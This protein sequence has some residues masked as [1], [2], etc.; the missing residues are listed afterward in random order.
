[1][2]IGAKQGGQAAE[3]P[4]QIGFRFSPAAYLWLRMVNRTRVRKPY[5]ASPEAV[6]LHKTLTIADLHCDALLSNRD[7][8]CRGRHGHVDI[9]RMQEGNVALQFF[10]IP[11]V[12]PVRVGIP[13]IPLDT[14][15]MTPL[16]A[17]ERWPK[18]TRKSTRERVLYGARLLQDVEA[19]SGGTFRILRTAAD[20]DAFLVERNR[21][22]QITAGVLGVEGLH[23][24]EGNLET[25]DTFFDA[26]VRTAGPVH[27]AD[28][29]L[30][31][32]AHG[33]KQGGLTPFGEA[34]LRRM[35]EKRML[36]DFAHASSRL[37]A[38][39]LEC[40]TRPPV[41][42]HTGL[43]G[44]YD[45][46]RNISDAHALRI[47]EMGGVI[48]IGFFPWALGTGG[49]N[50]LINTLLYAVRLVGPEHV[51]LGSDWDGMVLTPIDASGVVLITHLLLKH[52]LPETDIA[53]IMGGNVIRL[54]RETLPRE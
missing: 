29:D 16:L 39:M 12:A 2:S 51:A 50:A 9:P 43:K 19:R 10:S 21:N 44:A 30:G 1:M 7:L 22:P 28:N 40:C 6:Q 17:A 38:D 37:L 14:D 5:R 26:G 27:M 13:W 41:I 11:T 15:A 18:A 24:L 33:R 4:G 46:P 20:L 25:L 54:L 48:G 31:G 23:S 52:G 36:V 49:L 53:G 47:A 45:T 32:C 42:S 8:L 3:R 35:E 34:V